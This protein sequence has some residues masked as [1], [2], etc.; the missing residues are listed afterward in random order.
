MGRYY[1]SWALNSTS[2]NLSNQ[3][4][5]DLLKYAA[6]DACATY[7]LWEEINDFLK[8]NPQQASYDIPHNQLPA[9]IPYQSEYHHGYFYY[10]TAKHLVKDTVKIMMNGLAISLDEVI[11]L[12]KLLE[13]TVKEN[14]QAINDNALVKLYL[15]ELNAKERSKTEQ[16]IKD[17]FKTEDQFLT[18]FNS[19]NSI[20]KS[21]YM[22]ELA[23]L[24]GW[25]LPSKTLTTGAPNW[26][27]KQITHYAKNF[28]FLKDLVNKTVSPN[29]TLAILAMKKVS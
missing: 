19:K 13:E 28:I 16:S 29:S 23:L 9:K 2:F 10:N 15:N 14:I 26:S 7:K 12:E 4:N 1:G 5:S 20:H 17:K 8:D 6:I 21:Y 11:P 24:Q 27:H 25:T 3:Y 18:S 22:T